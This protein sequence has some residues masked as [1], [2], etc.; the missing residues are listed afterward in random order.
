MMI[1]CNNCGAEI[2]E[3]AAVCPY[4]GAVNEKGSEKKYMEKLEDI[5]EDVGELSDDVQVS[6]SK[7]L[8]KSTQVFII[9]AAAAAAVVLFFIAGRMIADHSYRAEY[10][11]SRV[12]AQMAWKREN[13]PKLDRLYSEEK[14]D[15]ILD[16]MDNTDKLEDTGFYDWEHADFMTRYSTYKVCLEYYSDIGQIGADKEKGISCIAESVYLVCDTGYAD[17]DTADTAA[18]RQYQAEISKKMNDVFGITSD[19]AARLYSD[20]LDDRYG[21]FKFSKC[22]KAAAPYYS[23]YKKSAES[24]EKK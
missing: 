22:F 3:D 17:M 2:S 10:S 1:I 16:I 13:I 20:S 9:A 7:E 4:C 8:K 6:Y 23:R 5:R 12:R 21:Y 24:R 15:S 14:Y 19:E 11:G 18:V